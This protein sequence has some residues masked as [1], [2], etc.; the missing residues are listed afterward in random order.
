MASSSFKEDVIIEDSKKAEEIM[1]ALK[2]PKDKSVQS[3]QPGK[4]PDN[5]SE[6]W[7]NHSN[8]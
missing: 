5:V 6:I 3:S 7:F 2:Q 8:K 1:H 4:L